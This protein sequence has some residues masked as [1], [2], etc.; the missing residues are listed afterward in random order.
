MFKNFVLVLFII[1]MCPTNGY[2]ETKQSN[3]NEINSW[4]EN[5][6]IYPNLKIDKKST[7][8]FDAVE[9]KILVVRF[10]ANNKHLSEIKNFYDRFFENSGWLSKENP[11][12]YSQWEKKL[13]NYSKRKFFITKIS[14]ELG[15]LNFVLENF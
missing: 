6:P 4:V 5:I 12:N 10:F 15:S 1:L 11:Q 13:N 2:P 8:E 14:S 9:G 7:V 3:D